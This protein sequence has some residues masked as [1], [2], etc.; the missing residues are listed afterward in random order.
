M[1]PEDS[2]TEPA[3]CFIWKSIN[4]EV[5]DFEMPLGLTELDDRSVELALVQAKSLQLVWDARFK[6]LSH[7]FQNS[8]QQDWGWM[9]DLQASDGGSPTWFYIR[10]T[11]TGL[12]TRPLG[13]ESESPEIQICNQL[14]DEYYLVRKT[15]QTYTSEL[16][17]AHLSP[18]SACLCGSPQRDCMWERYM[19]E[20]QLLSVLIPGC[21]ES[22]SSCYGK[23]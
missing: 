19:F 18:H 14:L 17:W 12:E 5:R 7:R 4:W 21:C 1:L 22:R 10:N 11:W 8:V 9:C 20:R 13:P 15:E 16:L 2:S 6:P 3:L 23:G